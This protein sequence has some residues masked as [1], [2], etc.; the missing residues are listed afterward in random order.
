VS[1]SASACGNDVADHCYGVV[2]SKDSTI[3]GA[4]VDLDPFCLSSPLS[5]FV[6]NEMWVIG[7]PSGVYFEEVGYL[8]Q[9]TGYPVN[10]IPGAGTYGFWASHK[11]GHA[12]AAHVILNDP[13]L[14]NRH[15]IIEKTSSNAYELTMSGHHATDIGQTMNPG[16][17]EWG[18]ETGSAASHSDG[19][20][21]NVKYQHGSTWTVGA[22][23]NRSYVR[24]YPEDLSWINFTT[25]YFAGVT[26]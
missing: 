7:E 22:P 24:D 5:S 16:F 2:M 6:T 8:R 1:E 10:G 15:L 18:S 20:G 21:T 3:M 19:M 11:P 23:A 26:C 17:A 25:D 14:V 12:Y 4:R 9:G 13:A